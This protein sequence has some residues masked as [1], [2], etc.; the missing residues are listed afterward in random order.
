MSDLWLNDEARHDSRL[1]D[2]NEDDSR[3]PFPISRRRGTR[4]LSR[5]LSRCYC[6]EESEKG[7]YQAD[8][9]DALLYSP[10]RVG[11]VEPTVR[12]GID[13]QSLSSIELETGMH[14]SPRPCTVS[15]AAV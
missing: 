4:T 10:K 6:T 2:R 9:H 12:R 11:Y 14:T 5:Y 7:C 3:A 13:P 8:F 15:E 1:W